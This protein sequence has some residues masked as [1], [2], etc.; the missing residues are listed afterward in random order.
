MIRRVVYRWIGEVG[1]KVRVVRK[2]MLADVTRQRIER[3]FKA[4]E[5]GVRGKR[6]EYRTVQRSTASRRSWSGCVEGTV[7]CW[8]CSLFFLFTCPLVAYMMVQ[9]GV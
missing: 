9:R 1:L 2:G 4:K 3:R 7:S 5:W 8:L 6:D